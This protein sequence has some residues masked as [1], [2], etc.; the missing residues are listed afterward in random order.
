M[1]RYEIVCT[2]QRPPD[3]PPDHARIT[4]VGL[5]GSAPGERYRVERIAA[6]TERKE[7]EFYTTDRHTRLP[8]DVIVCACTGSRHIRSRPDLSMSD[9]LDRLPRCP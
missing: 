8:V 2:R 7:H 5:R 9:N 3:Q 6:W 4:E 1:G